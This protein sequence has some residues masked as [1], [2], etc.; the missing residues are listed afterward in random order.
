MFYKNSKN[1][2]ILLH[3]TLP[4]RSLNFRLFYIKRIIN[5]FAINCINN[6]NTIIFFIKSL[7]LLYVWI[8]VKQF[9][10]HKYKITNLWLYTIV[11]SK[12]TKRNCAGLALLTK[13]T[14]M[15]K[16]GVGKYYLTNKQLLVLMSFWY[17]VNDYPDG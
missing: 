10:I 15:W 14:Q 13:S 8:S 5:A 17:F 7:L 12:F 11:S 6:I 16:G 1:L 4:I 2:L 9:Q 3:W